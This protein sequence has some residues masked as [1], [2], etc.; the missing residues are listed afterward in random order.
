M[1]RISHV[2][3][4]RPNFMKI[5]PIMQE[6]AKY[7]DDSSRSS[8][9]P[10]N[11]TTPTCR[12][13]SSKSWRCPPDKNL[14]VGSGS[15]AQQTALIMQ[16]IEPVLLEYTP[17]WDLWYPATYSTVACALVASK[18]GIKVAHVEAGLRSKDRAMPEEINRVLTDHLADAAFHH[19]AERRQEITAGRHPSREYLFRR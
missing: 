17:D 15:H 2:L 5:A 4:A 12:R 3:G 10:A 14:E 9:T 16:R 13:F 8:S 7:P 6:L 19:R 1:K 18:L 11:T